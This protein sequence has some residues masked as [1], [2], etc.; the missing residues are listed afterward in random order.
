MWHVQS[1]PEQVV[2]APAIASKLVTLPDAGYLPAAPEGSS[3][4]WFGEPATGT[5]CGSDFATIKQTPEDGCTSAQRQEGDLASPSFSL[6]GQGAAFLVFR[7]WWEIEAVNADIADLMQVQ[8]SVD[9]GTTWVPAGTLNPLDPAWGGGHQTYTDAGARQSGN[10]Q[11]YSADLSGAA[12]Q[13]DV[14]VRVHFD[15]VDNRRN[16]FRGLLLDGLAVVD[17]LGATID[18]PAAP[19]FTD[20]PPALSVTDTA[21]AQ[22][23]GGNW[24][25]SFTVAAGHPGSHPIGVDWAVHGHS[26]SPAGHGHATISSGATTTTAIAPVSGADAPYTVVLSNPTGATIAPGQGSS[27][28]PGGAVPLISLTGVQAAQAAPGT[29]TVAVPV[30]LSAPS[31]QV[32]TVRYD[33]TGSDGVPVG[34]G[35]L[36]IPAGATTTSTTLS[37]TAEH[38]PYTVGLSDPRGALLAPGRSSAST[39]PLVGTTPIATDS[40]LVLG[41]RTSGSGAVLGESFLL[42]SVSGTVRYHL[43]GQ[44]YTTLPPG[45]TVTLPFGT[46]VDATA[47]R[48]RITVE[49]DD[50]HNLQTGEFWEG[51]F[52]VFQQRQSRAIT[53]LRLAGGDFSVCPGASRK[54][55]K[56]SAGKVVR[57]LWGEAKGR[58][59]T[60]GR[61]A[62]ATVRG[63]K[64][65]TEDLCLATRI[66]VAE[67]IVDVY[68]SRRKTTTPV[69]AGNSRTVGAL[70]SARYRKRRGTHAPRLSSR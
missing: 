36:T 37:V 28:T 24:R 23:G 33:V 42:T 13:A 59:R 31:L 39:G 8:Y 70:Q 58:F 11:T 54:R 3:V 32:V 34:A 65:L 21:L 12:G 38:A 51:K 9:G 49:S 15:T 6:A 35:V 43:A 17:M 69:R 27:S 64:W 30:G 60:K 62:A 22:D 40:Q 63:T 41:A 26:G 56:R 29:L 45:T 4:D 46:V 55:A 7:G 18:A 2:V 68:D 1:Q 52:G 14:R 47:G 10:W 44:P 50:R 66:T 61:F 57:K 5:Y 25:V 48:A 20:A 53:E 19:G 16:G 67:G